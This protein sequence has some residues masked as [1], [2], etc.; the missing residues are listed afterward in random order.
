MKL[1]WA[2]K[3][4]IFWAT[5]VSLFFFC[6][7]GREAILGMLSDPKAMFVL[8]GIPWIILRLLDWICG[9]PAARRRYAP[10]R[11]KN[12]ASE[13][14]M[15]VG[16]GRGV[17]G[18]GGSDGRCVGANAGARKYALLPPKAGVGED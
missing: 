9:G 6:V 4:A 8:F 13:G 18:T 14:V 3:L 5:L 17:V 7:N 16:A 12:W 1:I 10:P 15:G 11:A 2:D